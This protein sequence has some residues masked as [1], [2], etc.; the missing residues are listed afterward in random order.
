[1]KRWRMAGRIALLLAMMTSLL[2]GCGGV[3]DPQGPVAK[4]QYFLIVLSF[5]IMLVVMIVVFVLFFY[6][7]VRYRKRKGQTGYPVQVEGSHK[8]EIIWT[9][10]PF[11]IV[12]VLGIITV[13]YTFKA[14]HQTNVKENMQVKVI[15][16]QFWWEFIYSDLDVRTAQDLVIPENTWVTVQLDSADVLHSFWIPQL[17]GKMDTNPGITN[18]MSFKSDV[19]GKTF[20]GK[21]AELCGTSHALMNFKVVTKTAD[22]FDAW[23]AKMKTP[24]EITAA[25]AAGSQVFT[26]K[27]IGC[28]AVTVDNASAGPNLAGFAN[29][30]KVAGYRDNTEDFLREWISD[31]QDMKPGTT[32]PKV[33]LSDQE[34]DDLVVFLQ[35]LK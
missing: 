23:L 20:R 1:M 14:E 13:V 7:L 25:T 18:R 24:V 5:V 8:L 26:N 31:P 11:I 15:A 28:H 12:M 17:A 9:V 29:R 33:P 2:T 34:V 6:A 21:C 22:E 32:M 4:D 35:S 10:I 16:H 27:C 19:A 30:E 3:F